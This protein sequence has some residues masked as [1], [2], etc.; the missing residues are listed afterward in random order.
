MVEHTF[1]EEDI[2]AWVKTPKDATYLI[3]YIM[4]YMFGNTKS[5][6]MTKDEALAEQFSNSSCINSKEVNLEQIDMMSDTD[7]EEGFKQ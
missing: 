5:L 2:P 4:P 7:I 1:G 6:P 3:P